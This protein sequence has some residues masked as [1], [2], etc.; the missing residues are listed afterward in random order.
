MRKLSTA[1]LIAG[2][3][4]I[5]VL[6]GCGGGGGGGGTTPPTPP[7]GQVIINGVV[8]DD[9]VLAL[10]VQGVLVKLNGVVK[11]TDAN[12]AF[13]F[14]LSGPPATLIPIPEAYFYVSTRTLNQTDYPDDFSVKYGNPA[15]PYSQLDTVDGA[16]IPI[17]INVFS[18]TSGTVS[19]GVIT[20]TYN[21]PNN[22]PPPPF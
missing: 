8:R 10:P 4:F 9:R 20:V 13:S 11:A 1:F 19:L 7:P 22:P 3:A 21:D 16:K 12:G 2:V 14:T 6:A 15:V 18:A 17:P 5:V